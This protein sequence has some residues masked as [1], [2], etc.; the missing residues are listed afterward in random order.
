MLKVSFICRQ[1]V[2]GT[3]WGQQ[4]LCKDLGRDPQDPS[5]CCE[6]VTER[7]APHHAL[8]EPLSGALASEREAH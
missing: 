2:E 3:P 1:W 6:D 4:R 7:C 5:L 8:G